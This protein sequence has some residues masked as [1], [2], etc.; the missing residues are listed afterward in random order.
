LQ[1][2]VVPLICVP[3]VIVH[4]NIQSDLGIIR[5][6]VGTIKQKPYMLGGWV[7]PHREQQTIP[8]GQPSIPPKYFSTP[9]ANGQSAP[10]SGS[11]RGV[12]RGAGSHTPR[13][14]SESLRR[15]LSSS[16]EEKYPDMPLEAGVVPRVCVPRVVVH[17]NISSNL[18]A[19]RNTMGMFE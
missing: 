14:A 11:A 4:E 18:R 3:R 2:C 8:Q 13:T 16:T 17:G 12:G 10:R 19:I 15:H 9:T 1:A 7:N 6:I 5:N